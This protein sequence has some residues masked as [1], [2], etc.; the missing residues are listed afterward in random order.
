MSGDDLGAK[1]LLSQFK[2]PSETRLGLSKT[3][4]QGRGG[5]SE[6][7]RRIAN[8]LTED[9]RPLME[10]GILKHL[11]NLPLFVEGI[12]RDITS[13]IVTRIAFGALIDFTH[14][15]MELYPQLREA[16]VKAEYQ[17]WDRRTHSWVYKE[18]ELPYIN[19]APILL[20]P[21]SWTG[22]S[23]LMS[24]DRYY[25]KT[26]LDWIQEKQTVMLPDGTIDRPTKDELR[27]RGNIPP[28]RLT[29]LRL[30]LEAYEVD[31]DLI[32]RFT[33]F[34]VQK[35]AELQLKAA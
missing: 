3:S 7:G 8:I 12:D 35:Q 16:T 21:E 30:T 33:A 11:E 25:N 9:L 14:E 27:E 26:L 29:I 28:N 19:G 22:K 34:V 31:I 10:V 23:L 6:I 4:F 5:A 20:V 2:E 32:E 13:D 15:M 1:R 18:V 24:A 17:L